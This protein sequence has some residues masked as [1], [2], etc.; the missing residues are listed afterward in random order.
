MISHTA[1]YALR[2]VVHL[3]ERDSALLTPVGEIASALDVPANYLSKILHQLARAGV[4]ESTRGP[5][6]GFRLGSAPEEISLAD[7]IGAFDSL[8]EQRRCLLGR[9]R[10]NDSNP[11]GAHEHYKLVK[12]PLTAFFRDTTIADV[13][14]RAAAH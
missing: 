4:V 13:L 8:K 9:P 7:V 5:H 12:E 11:C 14:A 2:A 1:E 6:G 10:C 3:A